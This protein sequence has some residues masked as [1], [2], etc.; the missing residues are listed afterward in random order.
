MIFLY[1]VT[2]EGLVWLRLLRAKGRGWQ[3][4]NIYPPGN[5]KYP[6]PGRH[7]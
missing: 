4:K 5:F 1:T 6:L 7:F 3:L 2:Q